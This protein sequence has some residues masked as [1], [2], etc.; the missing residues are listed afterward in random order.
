MEALEAAKQMVMKMKRTV[1]EE[2]RKKKL[3]E[4]FEEV[5]GFKP[6]VVVWSDN[7]TLEAIYR[8]DVRLYDKESG[9]FD[10][11][12]EGKR[13]LIVLFKLREEDE[14]GESV[15]DWWFSESKKPE[16]EDVD[17]YSSMQVYG[18]YVAIVDII[19]TKN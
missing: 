13:V 11:T 8:V 2:E 6:N 1:K 7:S 9:E 18:K 17:F 10:W 12:I 4:K 16:R 15:F 5:F 19:T 3:V 14:D